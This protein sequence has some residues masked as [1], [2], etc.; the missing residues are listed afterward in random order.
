MY[1]KRIFSI[2]IIMKNR[3]KQ[4]AE[5]HKNYMREYYR[6]NPDKKL[7]QYEKNKER[8]HKKIE[9][10]VCKCMIQRGNLPR[11]KKTQKCLKIKNEKPVIVDG[12]LNVEIKNLSK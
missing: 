3:N 6:K 7:K 2:Y 4:Q 12:K 11:H 9:C 8:L 10:D 1:L 5:A